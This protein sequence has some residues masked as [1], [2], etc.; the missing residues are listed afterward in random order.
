MAEAIAT[1]SLVCNVMQVISFTG[2]VIGMCQ[3]MREDGSP[4]P[5]LASN[6]A[7]LSALAST[8]EHN[9]TDFDPIAADVSDEASGADSETQQA[10]IRLKNLASDLIRNIKQ[11]QELLQKVAIS[12]SDRRL[13]RVTLGIKYKL[14][15]QAQISSLEKRI[16]GTRNTLSVEL[17]SRVCSS[18][19][20]THCRSEEKFSKLHENMKQFIER[21]SEGKRAISELITDESQKTRAHVT[22]E[23]EQTRQELSL[24]VVSESSQRNLEETRK[25]V[26]STLW[27]PEM[28]QRE[29]NITEASDDIAQQIF[30]SSGIADWLQSN[31]STFWISGKA[32]SGKSTL[33]KH[34][35]HS[36]KTIEYLQTW[37]SSAQIF[38]FFFYELGTNILQRQL[39]GCLCTL[40]HQILHNDRDV[41]EQL[42]KERPAVGEKLSEHDWSLRELRDALLV[43]LHH[44]ASAFCLILD[45]LD[46]IIDDERGDVLE[47]V[48]CLGRIETVKVCTASR[49]EHLF[50][51]RLGSYPSLRVQDINHRVIEFYARKTLDK[52]RN[53]FEVPDWDYIVFLHRLVNKSDGVFL[54]AVMAL[55][56]LVEGIE[57]HIDSWELLKQRIEEFAPD[58]YG[59]Y[60]QMRERQNMDLPIYKQE[61]AEIFWYV[62]DWRDQGFQLSYMLL[63]CLLRTHPK[64]RGELQRLI[65]IG[66][67]LTS[68]DEDRISR[69]YEGWLSARSAG[70]L[71]VITPHLYEDIEFIHRSVREF[72]KGTKEGQQIMVHDGISV[73]A[74]HTSYINAAR[75][76]SYVCAAE[77]VDSKKNMRNILFHYRMVMPTLVADRLG[78]ESCRKWMPPVDRNP[79]WIRIILRA[80]AEVGDIETLNQIDG[81]DA[82]RESISLQEKS[83]ILISC[84][85]TLHF[86]GW[87]VL[88]QAPFSMWKGPY[89]P[90]GLVKLHERKIECIK[91]L[92]KY[93]A[94]PHTASKRDSEGVLQHFYIVDSLTRTAFRTFLAA[95]FYNL[96]IFY[97]QERDHQLVVMMEKLIADI[98]ACINVF[99]S[100]RSNDQP[101]DIT[102]KC[103]FYLSDWR[104]GNY[105]PVR[106]SMRITWCLEILNQITNSSGS[107]DIQALLDRHMRW[108][109]IRLDAIRDLP[110]WQRPAAGN[111]AGEI[112]RYKAVLGDLHGERA[113]MSATKF[114]DAKS[115]IVWEDIMID[116][117]DF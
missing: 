27:F 39:R 40:I 96:L 101:N 54:W 37:K 93:G 55:K 56:S 64:L 94:D 88:A 102:T 5:G 95:A 43:C 111:D 8:L 60:K 22:A 10:R 109:S 36:R 58:L 15:Y 26:L 16:N 74:K 103:W 44:R 107:A 116:E 21:W 77:S 1:L 23:A 112:T 11:L 68:D 49:P 45:G 69:E 83:E 52:Y 29:N 18:T 108:D 82:I 46:E 19:Q 20:A 12:S 89:D 63:C 50:C 90:E 85:E 104:G 114:D 75:E 30:P 7:H 32:G 24:L 59:L 99:S 33:V 66:G 91:W 97:Q 38:R 115:K 106:F 79:M 81:M 41:L 35:I 100:P 28:N 42:L 57:K 6:M 71:Q 3:R 14:Y 13:G 51:Q 72:L 34:L 65:S 9:T 98:Q 87:G 92:V 113:A 4:E 105:R 62:M 61:A 48:E 47:L 70:L 25:R 2:E 17:L 117:D 78:A 110:G 73:E 31:Q 53:S 84:C 86:S 76:A 80:S 67:L